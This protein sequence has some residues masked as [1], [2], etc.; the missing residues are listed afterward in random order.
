VAL[1]RYAPHAGQAIA[2][3][4]DGQIGRRVG[5]VF[6]SQPRLALQL[7]EQRRAVYE[8]R[9]LHSVWWWARSTTDIVSICT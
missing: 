3:V 6:K 7:I 9:R 2:V 4:L 8:A 1:F 5:P